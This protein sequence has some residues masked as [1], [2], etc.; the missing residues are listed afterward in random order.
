MIGGRIPVNPSGGLACFGEA[1][2]AQALWQAL[3]MTFVV[4]AGSAQLAALPLIAAGVPIWV[5]VF[6]ALMVNLRFVIFSAVIGPHFSHLRWPKRLWY[7]YLNVDLVMAFFPQRFPSHTVAKPAGKVGFFRGLVIPNWWAWQLGTIAGILLAS[8][9]PAGWG[10]GFA[11]TLALLALS[12]SLIT[13]RVTVITALVAATAAVARYLALPG[14]AAKR[15]GLGPCRAVLVGRSGCRKRRGA[16]AV[17]LR[18]PH[19][20]CS[21]RCSRGRCRPRTHR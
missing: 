2:P 15:N 3:A 19:G 17:G 5:T 6:T 20:A 11:G 10:I 12:C 16:H 9:I 21:A 18:E 8:Q 4:Y 1:V 13:D 7:G 14:K